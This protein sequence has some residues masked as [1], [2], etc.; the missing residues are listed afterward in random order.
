MTLKSVP[1]DAKQ[2]V[3]FAIRGSQTLVD[4][5]V[6]VRTAPATPDSFLADAGNL[7]H[8]GFL[9]VACRMV[10]PAAAHLRALLED[11]PE[12]KNC[13][14]VFTGHSAGGA[15]ASLLYAHM[16]SRSVRSELTNLA[17]SFQQ[18]HC[19]T[20]G[21]PPVSLLPLAKPRTEQ[22]RS[23]LF[24]AFVNEGDPV[25]R[26]DPDYFRSL[27]DLYTSPAPVTADA[28]AGPAPKFKL[29]RLGRPKP[30]RDYGLGAIV[31]WPLPTGALSTAG[32]IVVVRRGPGALDSE[33]DLRVLAVSDQQLR[34]VVYGDLMMHQMKLYASR[35]ESLAI[36]TVT[37]RGYQ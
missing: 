21:A 23:S 10:R 15:V 24:L 22:Y 1:V 8:A 16:T 36:R 3:V 29:F 32:R 33:A 13:S 34:R 4:W 6:N 17:G 7:C 28:L 35:V 31:E 37:A 26:L 20:F 9:A 14:L 30:P 27:L 25:P 18:V 19:F 12:R 11:N 5:A 2:V